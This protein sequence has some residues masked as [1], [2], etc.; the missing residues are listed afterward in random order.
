[1]CNEHVRGKSSGYRDGETFSVKTTRTLQA[2]HL[3]ITH[4]P[5]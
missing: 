3:Y 5:I 1:M 2:T 4:V